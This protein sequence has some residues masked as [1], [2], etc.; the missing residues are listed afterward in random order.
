MKRVLLILLAAVLVASMLFMGMG[1]KEPEIVV[2]T[3]VETV[4]ETVEIEAPTEEADSKIPEGDVTLD[5]WMQDSSS[6]QQWL[7]AYI[8][9]FEAKYPNITIN[10]SYIPYGDL[11]EKLLPSIAAGDEPAIMHG[12]DSWVTAQDVSGIFMKLTPDL[13]TQ[14][15]LREK[16]Y[17]NLALDHF[18]D[19]NGDIYGI[20]AWSGAA[21]GVLYHKDVV[22]EV[23]ID[24]NAIEKW[25]QLEEA[26]KKIV[27]YY[28]GDMRAFWLHPGQL[29][30]FALG[31]IYKWGAEDK[32]FDKESGVWDWTIPESRKIHEI[33]LSWGENG[34]WDVDAGD[35]H[36]VFPTKLA[37]FELTGPWGKG[38]YSTNYPELDM[39]Y[40]KMPDFYETDGIANVLYHHSSFMLSSKLEGDE[41]LAAL[42]Y[43]R[44]IIDN[45]SFFN[46]PL[47]GSDWGGAINIKQWV[48]YTLERAEAGKETNEKVITM[49]KLSEDFA[50]GLIDSGSMI[51]RGVIINNLVKELTHQ[52][53]RGDLTLDEF[54]VEMTTQ[55][56]IQEADFRDQ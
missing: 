19:E 32:L 41:K 27:E 50:N 36:T 3:V 12:Y 31:H 5:M 28:N 26:G 44:E 7:N 23:G 16:L 11:L 34:L 56:N 39:D 9:V 33:M 6:H 24:M 52:L 37:A 20:T 54:L 55:F 25:E 47:E 48:D 14:E 17:V 22:D 10:V 15:E 51:P 30:N 53:M 45:P 29:G 38:F 8:P 18:T 40:I 43:V 35:V 2:E 49:A 13:Y 1:C 46:M 4:T 42:L 21:G